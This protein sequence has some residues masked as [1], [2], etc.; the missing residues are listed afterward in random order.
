MLR[1]QWTFSFTFIEGS[2]QTVTPLNRAKKIRRVRSISLSWL[3][4][5]LTVLNWQQFNCFDRHSAIDRGKCINNRAIGQ[6]YQGTTTN[7]ILHERSWLVDLKQQSSRIHWNIINFKFREVTFSIE[8]MFM[9]NAGRL[10]ETLS[11]L[12]KRTRL[13]DYLLTLS[14]HCPW[15]STASTLNTHA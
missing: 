8:V 5:S 12:S 13:I 3:G 6:S 9:V 1:I 2:F 4:G 7:E 10:W 14:S 15:T 11:L